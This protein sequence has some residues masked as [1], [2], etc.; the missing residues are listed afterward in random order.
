MTCGRGRVRS[1]GR[2]SGTV[3]TMPRHHGAETRPS[4]RCLLPLCCAPLLERTPRSHSERYRCRVGVQ[5]T[6]GDMATTCRRR[7]VVAMGSSMQ[8]GWTATLA[9][10]AAPRASSVTADGPRRRTDRLRVRRRHE[11]SGSAIRLWQPASADGHAPARDPQS[12]TPGSFW[13]LRSVRRRR[14]TRP[15]S[16]RG[17]LGAGPAVRERELRRP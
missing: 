10:I 2:R 14:A 5:T 13:L 11:T 15:G 3:A 4:S 7:E 17:R 6:G 12:W 9:M 1:A 8:T 16:H